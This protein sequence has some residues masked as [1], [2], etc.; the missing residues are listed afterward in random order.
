MDAVPV[1]DYFTVD[2]ISNV[3]L[4]QG[5]LQIG[6]QNLFNNQYA[7]VQSQ[8]LSGFNEIFNA[9]ASGIN[10]RVGYKINF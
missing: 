7:P 8:F 5:T 6:I 3:K 1:T 2:Y 9:A 4:G 10:L